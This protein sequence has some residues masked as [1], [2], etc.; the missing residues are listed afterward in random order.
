MHSTHKGGE[1]RC[2]M[3]SKLKE[4]DAYHALSVDCV[5]GS[6]EASPT[7]LSALEAAQRLQLYG[8][9]ELPATPA[10]HSVVRFLSHFN[11]ALIYF[12]LA[13]AVVTW[14]L[15]HFVDASVILAVVLVNA[16]VG[17][18]QEGKAE[19]ALDAIRRMVSPE[20]TVL[21]D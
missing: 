16:I 5:L 17:F 2:G 9:N 1:S 13:A 15:G 11:N 8:P 19:S 6:A 10:R 4:D 3:K 21:R 12:L 14:S 7:G 18:I 20:A